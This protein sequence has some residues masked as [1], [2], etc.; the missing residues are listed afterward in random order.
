MSNAATRFP[1]SEERVNGLPRNKKYLIDL[2]QDVEGRTAQQPIREARRGLA[3]QC[4]Q[5]QQKGSCE[6]DNWNGIR[7]PIAYDTFRKC[8]IE[9]ESFLHFKNKIKHGKKKIS[10][11]GINVD[12]K[13]RFASAER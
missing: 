5:Q 3:R 2:L 9:R 10:N 13:E 12:R 7:G 8:R 11:Y 6:Y 4:E 1:S